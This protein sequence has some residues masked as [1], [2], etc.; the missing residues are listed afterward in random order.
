MCLQVNAVVVGL[1]RSV[2]YYKLQMAM[3]YILKNNAH[4][5]VRCFGY[6]S[7]ICHLVGGPMQIYGPKHSTP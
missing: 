5:V 2:N 3:S 1:D 4:F 7:V 6:V